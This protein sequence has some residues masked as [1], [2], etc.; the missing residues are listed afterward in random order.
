MR[1]LRKRGITVQQIFRTDPHSDMVPTVTRLTFFLNNSGKLSSITT[2]TLFM[3]N[4]DQP[5]ERIW[6]GDK[7]NIQEWDFNDAT[8][9]DLR[10]PFMEL[11]LRNPADF[12]TLYNTLKEHDEKMFQ[13]IHSV[14]E[15]VQQIFNFN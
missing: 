8:P 15:E 1:D 2:H 10:Y 14:L 12:K 6:S 13:I 4:S 11:A 3:E 5:S 7:N 9:S